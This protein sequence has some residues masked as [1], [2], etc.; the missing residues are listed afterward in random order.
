M[1]E[2]KYGADEGTH[3]FSNF[4]VSG[5]NFPHFSKCG[6]CELLH[7]EVWES[8]ANCVTVPTSSKVC[9][10]K[11]NRNL[12]KKIKRHLQLSCN[13]Q[14]STLSKFKIP[15]VHLHEIFTEILVILLLHHTSTSVIL[16]QHVTQQLLPLSKPI[17]A[18]P[19]MQNQLRRAKSPSIVA[20]AQL[21][22]VDVYSPV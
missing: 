14:S 19:P 2:D 8:V 7:K 1:S 16:P 3:T 11:L 4:P 20:V 21:A 12:S 17:L 13:P 18:V 6:K 9:V 22:D 10:E 15:Q 5:V